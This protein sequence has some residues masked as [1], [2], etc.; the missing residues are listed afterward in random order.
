MSLF[1]SLPILPA[2]GQF[3]IFV[4]QAKANLLLQE[5]ESPAVSHRAAGWSTPPALPFPCFTPPSFGLFTVESVGHILLGHP[6]CL[7]LAWHTLQLPARLRDE[8]PSSVPGHHSPA[9]SG[10]QAALGGAGFC[11]GTALQAVHTHCPA[12]APARTPGGLGQLHRALS[13]SLE[14]DLLCR[15]C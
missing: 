10:D 12:S 13:C 11:G 5:V 15:P 9:P 3:C 6:P 14:Q 1:T 4:F 8:A 2:L 7:A